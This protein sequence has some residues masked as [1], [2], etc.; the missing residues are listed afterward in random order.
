[1]FLNPSLGMALDRIAERAADVRRA[2]TPGALPAHDDVATVATVSDFALDPLA[3]VAPD[4]TY[5]VTADE[6]GRRSYARDGS[7]RLLEG[8]LVDGGGHRIFGV[9]VPGGALEE[10][11][12]DPVDE[13]LG[14]VRDAAIEPDGTL[15]YRR[16]V[17]DPRSGATEL[18][19]VVSGRIALAR[20][21]AGTRLASSDGSHGVAPLGVD[22]QNGSPGDGAFAS[23]A[24]MRR[25]RSRVNI[26]ESLV[27]LKEAYLAFDA[28][29][30]AEASKAHLGKTAMDLLK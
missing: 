23:L 9:R 8:R 1:M 25:E 7:F 15:V 12:V 13:S 26:D 24:P 30:A 21:P 3:V 10:L 4:G 17:V 5:F 20:F 16:E 14:R 6:Q 27:R 2:Y 29:A 28:L 19:R 18:Q 11:G 22:V